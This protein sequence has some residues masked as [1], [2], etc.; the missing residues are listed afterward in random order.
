[1]SLARFDNL[2]FDLNFNHKDTTTTRKL[3]SSRGSPAKLI[4]NTNLTT[5]IIHM[6]RIAAFIISIIALSATPAA[7]VIVHHELKVI[8]DPGSSRLTGEDVVEIQP[9]GVKELNFSLA[10]AATDVQMSVNGKPV[11]FRRRPQGISL[12]V[13]DAQAG[14]RILVAISYAAVFDDPVPLRPVN[15]DNP[16]F[17]VTGSIQKEGAFLLPGAGWYPHVD[18]RKATY[19]LRVEAPEG[20]VAVSAGRSLGR[21]TGNGK[22]VSAWRVDRP[23]RGLSLSAGRYIVTEK[24]IGS[25]TAATYFFEESR[26]LSGQYLDAVGGYIRLYEDLFGPYPFAKFAI[27]ENYFP[28][29]YGFP[30][31]TL[32]GSQV[33]RLPFIVRTSLG[34]EIAHC[35]W[36]NGVYVDYA[37]GN[38]SEGLTTY[39]ADYLYQETDSPDKAREYRRQLLRNYAA[40][41]D[42]HADFALGDFTSRTNPATKAIGYD[43]SAMVFHMLRRRIGDGAFWAALKDVFRDHLFDAI[44]WDEFRKAFERRGKVDL[45]RFFT[46]WI[47]RSGAPELAFE[48]VGLKSQ[49]D[50]YLVSGRIVQ[51]PPFYD[52]IAELRLIA[53]DGVV[54]ESVRINGSETDFEV[55][56]SHPPQV[57]TLD[58]DTDIFRRLAPSEIPPSVNSVK[59]AGTVLAVLTDGSEKDLGPAAETLVRALGLKHVKTVP[60]NRLNHRLMADSDLIFIGLPRNDKYMA[61]FGSDIRLS[62]NFFELQGRRFASP[63][64][65]FFGVF[66]HPI[67][68]HRS[69]ALFLPLSS[70]HAETVARKITHY[71][72]YSYLVF[73]GAQNH[74]K[75]TWPVT[76]SPLIYRWD[77]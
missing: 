16:G 58:P 71:G 24:T 13:A 1:M 77:R 51:T 49:S 25:V 15:T 53:E 76:D 18:A 40:L 19:A 12:T 7:A 43:K 46:Q 59:G 55:I 73:Q 36:G 21:N 56:T 54:T 9:E 11:S 74:L 30:S 42:P 65:T 68:G 20:I 48:R 67:N 72:K 70:R 75:G 45:K 29:G 6:N 27:V 37:K 66:N 26:D 61:G 39:V 50:R 63:E 44:S 32:L 5:K 69:A 57:V 14:G 28:T 23:V 31:Y 17:G 64:H 47:D 38:W 34:H 35:W 2:P 62:R 8:L 41:V 4:R 10:D 52:L 22:T 33:L 3:F 60:E